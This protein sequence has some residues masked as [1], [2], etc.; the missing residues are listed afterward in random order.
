[1]ERIVP[2]AGSRLRARMLRITAADETPAQP[3]GPEF[4]N[5]DSLA[6]GEWWKKRPT[7]RNAPPPMDVPRDQ[8]VAFALYTQDRG[9]LKLTAQLY[10]LKPDE[11]REVRL[12]FQRDG[13]WREAA[14]TE[15]VLP[16]WSALFRVENWDASQDT[17][18]RV[19]HGERIG[20]GRR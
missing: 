20:E 10:P 19:R 1:M 7:G 4:P 17:P 11:P 5:L 15:V 18:Y 9:V 14:R 2:G 13:Q 12:E 6:S 16:G 8:V 3:F